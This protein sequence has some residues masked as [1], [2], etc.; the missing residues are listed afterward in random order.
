MKTLTNTLLALMIAIA[1]TSCAS[2]RGKSTRTAHVQ[3]RS[4]G[5]IRVNGKPV[6]IDRIGP[7]LKRKG[8][9]RLSPVN[10]HVPKDISPR[11]LKAITISLTNNGFHRVLF[12]KPKQAVAD[13]ADP[14]KGR[15]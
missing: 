8:V 10:I 11:I 7:T 12:V 5:M 1:F 3:V 4:S 6:S 2:S 14:H 15:K 13:V 9:G